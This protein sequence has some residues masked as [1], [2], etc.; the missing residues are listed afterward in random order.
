MAKLSKRRQRLY[1]LLAFLL[2]LAIATTLVMFAL[3]EN[4][5]YFR[6]PT[7]IVNGTYPEHT[8]GRSFRLGGLVEKGSLKHFG[9]TMTFSVTDMKNNLT[10]SYTGLPPDLFREG[11]GVIA[12][13][14]MGTN[15]LFMAD[16]LLAKH[17][18]KYMPPEVARELRDQGAK[19]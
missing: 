8:S 7:E 12:E 9:T 1:G 19:P 11:Q 5:S 10:V 18:E 6:T 17:D 4:I 14:K 16:T 15:G 2:G 13:G 3:R